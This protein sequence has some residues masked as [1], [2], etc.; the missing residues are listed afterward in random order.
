MLRERNGPN[1]KGKMHFSDNKIGDLLHVNNHRVSIGLYVRKRLGFIIS[2]MKF[3]RYLIHLVLFIYI[4]RI[5]GEQC[6]QCIHEERK[7]GRKKG[8]TKERIN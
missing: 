3:N 4:H 6:I 2:T 1:R 7:K 8:G 5:C